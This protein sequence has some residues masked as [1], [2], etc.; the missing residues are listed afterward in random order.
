MKNQSFMFLPPGVR[1]YCAAFAVAL[2][3][4]ASVRAQS[5]PPAPASTEVP[6]TAP[7]G[8]AQQA[9]PS[10][11]RARVD[12]P[13]ADL[14]PAGE[15]P[16]P[17]ADPSSTAGAGAD[18]PS[19]TPVEVTAATRP[20]EDHPA[21]LS[22]IAYQPGKGLHVESEDSEFGLN[23]RTRAQL[24]YELSRGDGEWQQAMQER[25][26]RLQLEGNFFGRN[27][28]F[29]VE[30]ALSPRDVGMRDGTAPQ[31][32]PLLDYYFDFTHL[33]DLSLRVG[34]YKVPFN[35]Q[36]V[37]SS[38][39]M[40]F[41]D[42]SIVNGEFN[43]D[44]DIGFDFRSKDF[45]GLDLLR[46]YAGVFVGEGRNSQRLADFGLMYLA[47]IEVLPFGTFDDY[48]EGD[49]ERNETPKLS[50][51]VGYGYLDRAPHD[52][53]ILGS[54]FDDGGTVDLHLLTA[55]AV[56]RL[57]GLSLE[58]EFVYRSGTRNAGPGGPA[59]IGT[60]PLEGWGIMGQLGYLLPCSGFEVAVRG[61]MIRATGPSAMA[62]ENEYGAGINYY[63]DGHPFK[64]QL[65]Y[66]RL[67]E[68]EVNATAY[69]W[70]HQIRLQL[71]GGL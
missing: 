66:F 43:L 53:G 60:E 23:I 4:A 65:D 24:L 25:R 68:R 2:V 45:L 71:Q 6:A 58:S 34:Q 62:D 17:V 41:V 14:S 18:S 32:S 48:S 20:S 16:T 15:G 30:L 54:Q 63:F 64:V 59:S 19:A 70:D 8:V 46:Y 3:P 61:S 35:R 49:L 51:G 31:T 50:L 44:R 47:R 55:D 29:K 39:N 28:R 13:V 36:R 67:G 7:P 1:P 11:P 21:A 69:A 52:R 22:K 57:R 40:R 9:P 26:A 12:V 38:A 27:N 56:F 37:V 33:R 5:A 42:R 10:V